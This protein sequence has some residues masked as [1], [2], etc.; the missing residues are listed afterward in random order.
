MQVADRDEAHGAV[1]AF[2]VRRPGDHHQRHA[3]RFLD[4]IRQLA[5]L[6]AGHFRT[7]PAARFTFCSNFAHFVGDQPE[8]VEHRP[9]PLAFL[10][11]DPDHGAQPLP[12]FVEGGRRDQ[13]FQSKELQPAHFLRRQRRQEHREQAR[14][15]FP[16]RAHRR[17]VHRLLLPLTRR[18]VLLMAA[19]QERADHVG[20]RPAHRGGEPQRALLAKALPRLG[21]E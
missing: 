7:Q 8:D 1:R 4:P 10:L 2:V 3:Q 21:L 9:D 15:R 20:E 14:F 5:G 13:L 12:D 16:R 6:Q 18:A 11:R 17:D 19:A